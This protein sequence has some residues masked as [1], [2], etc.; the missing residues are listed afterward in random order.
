MKRSLFPGVVIL[1]SI[2]ALLFGML[3]VYAQ[4]SSIGISNWV[5]MDNERDVTHSSL[6]AGDTYEVF[7]DVTVDVDLP[8]TTLTLS[9][10]LEKAGDVYWSLENEY[11]GV[12]T[13]TWQPGMSSIDFSALKGMAQFSVKGTIPPDLTKEMLENGEILHQVESLTLVELSIGAELLSTIPSEVTDQAIIDYRD[14]L[15]KKQDL[16]RAASIAPEYESLAE[17]VISQ[18]EALSD[19][20]YVQSARNLLNTLPVSVAGF[21]APPSDESSLPLI[22]VIALLAVVLLVL[23]FLFLRARSTSSLIRQ[24]IDDESGRLDVLLVRVSK[25]DK[26]LASD[27]EQVKEQLEKLGGR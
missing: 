9:T 12:D 2:V 6:V 14:E 5:V 8:D 23:F 25:L 17:K 7:F 21:P 16:L 1:L 26:Q 3:P 22:V 10:P 4:T 15:D 27:I 18:A 11:E 24:Q 19:E 20:G 13:D